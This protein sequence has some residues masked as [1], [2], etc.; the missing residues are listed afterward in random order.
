MRVGEAIGDAIVAEGIDIAFG[1]IGEGNIAVAQRLGENPGVRWYAARRE[2]AVVSM[3]DGYMRRSGVDVGFAT[4]TCGPGFTNAVTAIAEARKAGTPLVV[5]TGDTPR[6]E[7]LHPQAIDE[8]TFAAATGAGVH[9]VRSP[10]TAVE[11]VELAF[12]RARRERRPIVLILSADYADQLY[13]GPPAENDARMHALSPDRASPSNA[14]LSEVA[15]AAGTAERPVILAG[16]GAFRAGASNALTE[17]AEQLGAPLATT[18]RARGLFAGHRLEVGMAGGFPDGLANELLQGA[19][20]V[21]AFG[22][23]LSDQTTKAGALFNADDV[24]LFDPDPEACVSRI[25]PRRAFAADVRVAAEALRHTIAN[26]SDRAAR[27][28]RLETTLTALAERRS[29]DNGSAQETERFDAMVLAMTIDALAPASRNVVVDLGYFTPEACRHVA[30]NAPGRFIYTVN[31]GSIGLSLATAAGASI[32][33]PQVP[34]LALVGDGGLLMS[35]GELETIG[36]YRLPVTVVVFDDSALGIE[37]HALRLRQGDPH[38]AAFPPVDFASVARAFG[39]E[40]VT[41]HSAHELHQACSGS[42]V[43]QAPFLID[44]RVDG[45]VETD[46]LRELVDAGWHQHRQS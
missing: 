20:L 6:E 23:S 25:R 11:D 30:V 21:L 7:P 28:A 43:W 37:Y 34:T 5:L 26:R 36:R 40:A 18:L 22:T 3:A 4:V 19:D 29:A 17:L 1:L 45:T 8:H 27:R 44:A 16:R 38:L 31:F 12:R 9:Q 10:V 13:S 39:I 24:V 35:I 42:E 2:D 41:V 33:D 14:I 32:A 46:W 15:D